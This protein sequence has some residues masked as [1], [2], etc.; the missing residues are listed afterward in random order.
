MLY[1]SKENKIC[2]DRKYMVRAFL[3]GFLTAFLPV[4]T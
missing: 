2:P 1:V 3:L 4:Y